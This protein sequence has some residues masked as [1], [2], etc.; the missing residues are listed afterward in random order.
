M[1]KFFGLQKNIFLLGLIS[2]FNDL[3]SE[4]I[5]SV[6]PGFFT[7]VLKTG[8]ASLGLVEGIA[9]AGTNF[10]KIYAGSLSDRIQKRKP[11]IVSGYLL[12]VI[13]RPIYLLASSVGGVIGIRF[14]ID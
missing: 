4:M 8:A 6:L 12:S 9:D 7:S 13:T 2:F 10:I 5:L 11:F 1:K 3:S 14:S